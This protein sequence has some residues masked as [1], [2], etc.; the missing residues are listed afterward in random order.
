MS[1]S[2]STSPLDDRENIPP[3]PPGIRAGPLRLLALSWI[4]VTTSLL[5]VTAYMA[6]V[7]A[8]APSAR[9][10]APAGADASI[11]GPGYQVQLV[12]LDPVIKDLGGTF[13]I[14]N[15]GSAC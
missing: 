15:D 1:R 9:S 11:L 13:E 5:P 7:P 2:Q 8:S 4:L 6:Q 14:L 10:K 3:L 12:L